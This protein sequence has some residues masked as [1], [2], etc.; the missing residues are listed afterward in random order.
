MR[1]SAEAQ[2]PSSPKPICCDKAALAAA[3]GSPGKSAAVNGGTEIQ[4]T[5]SVPG[6]I[7]TASPS[8]SCTQSGNVVWGLC[9]PIFM[10][11]A[12]ST[13]PFS[14]GAGQAACT[15]PIA[16]KQARTITCCC[17]FIKWFIAPSSVIVGQSLVAWFLLL[18]VRYC[19]FCAYSLVFEVNA[20]TVV[21]LPRVL[22][23]CQ[24]GS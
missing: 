15:V 9:G 4:L 8:E 13:T 20:F 23:V 5:R 2:K 24:I 18:A 21:Q 1:V 7:S 19:W 10:G 16:V 3:S 17:F 12:P 14:S 22:V 6:Q 11:V